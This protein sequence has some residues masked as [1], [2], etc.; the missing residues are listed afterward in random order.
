MIRQSENRI[1]YLGTTIIFI[2]C[3]FF[4][5]SFHQ[6]SNNPDLSG[7][8]RYQMTTQ[9]S[10]AIPSKDVPQLSS[11]QGFMS[12]LDETN[13]IHLSEQLKLFADNRLINQRI[14]SLHKV[15]LLIKP[16]FQEFYYHQQSLSSEDI[17]ILS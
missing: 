9:H 7:V 6:N 11:L 14:G 12:K 16:V 3:F 15:A 5:A 4:L 2:L 13:F 1:E 17:L 10:V 8:F